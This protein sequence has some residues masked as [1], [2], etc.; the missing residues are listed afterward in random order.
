[1]ADVDGQHDDVLVI[2]ASKDLAD[3]GCIAIDFLGT[4][5]DSCKSSSFLK[6]LSSIGANA[7]KSRPNLNFF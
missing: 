4:W 6:W 3:H 7:V 2:H 5:V 1:M